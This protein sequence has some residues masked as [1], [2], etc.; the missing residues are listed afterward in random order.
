MQLRKTFKETALARSGRGL[1]LGPTQVLLLLAPVLEPELGARTV[2]GPS[3]TVRPGTNH[4]AGYRGNRRHVSPP[5]VL[6]CFSLGSSEHQP[7]PLALVGSPWGVTGWP[8]LGRALLRSTGPRR[9]LHAAPR[10][11][12]RAR[13]VVAVHRSPPGGGSSRHLEETPGVF[14]TLC[15]LFER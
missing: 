15:H 1:K 9:L 10:A 12:A 5:P 8:P 11:A 2:M 13:L 4:S 14:T 3:W 6:T 7:A